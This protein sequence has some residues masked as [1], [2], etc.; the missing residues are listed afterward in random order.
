MKFNAFQAL[1]GMDLKEYE[2]RFLAFHS[3]STLIPLVDVGFS[4]SFSSPEEVTKTIDMIKLFKPREIFVGNEELR[5]LLLGVSKNVTV[6]PYFE[7]GGFIQV[8]SIPLKVKA[9]EKVKSL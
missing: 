4:I 9:K 8:A 5:N 3:F 7:E 1:T 2:D 6:T